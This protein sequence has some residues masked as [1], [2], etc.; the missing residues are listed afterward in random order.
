MSAVMFDPWMPYYPF[1]VIIVIVWTSVHLFRVYKQTARI[2]WGGLTCCAAILAIVLTLWL[3]PPIARVR[4]A[5]MRRYL[6]HNLEAARSNDPDSRQR[7]IKALSD[8]FVHT[9]Q[10]DIRAAAL[11]ALIAVRANEAIAL[12][13]QVSDTSEDTELRR[14]TQLA[15]E[16][17]KETCPQKNP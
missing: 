5:A 15:V 3:F 12:L 1:V 14:R 17:L 2:S 10:D 13:S 4:E 11:D 9:A 16:K 7:G 6:P 8:T